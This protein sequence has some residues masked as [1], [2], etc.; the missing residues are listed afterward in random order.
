MKDTF[1]FHKEWMD[2][3]SGL[4]GE[5]RLDIYEAIIMYGT[6]GM[7]PDLK[8]MAMLA[9]NFAKAALD[10]DNERYESICRRNQENG[11]KGGR[12]Q[13]VNPEEPKKPSGLFGN[14]KNPEEPK[15]PNNDIISTKADI[16]SSIKKDS[17]K[18]EPKESG[19]TP[20]SAEPTRCMPD[21]DFVS[22][23]EYYNTTMAGCA[24]PAIKSLSDARR[25]MLNARAKECGKDALAEVVRKA[26]AS[27]F[28]NGGGD[29][30]F[31]ASFDWIFR[32]SNFLKILEGNYDNNDGQQQQP[33]RTVYQQQQFDNIQAAER[34]VL[35]T[36]RKTVEGGRGLHPA[37]PNNR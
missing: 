22:F 35:E 27:S 12:P 33:R 4:P 14:P 9:F 23:L 2:A 36:I 19:G 18:A 10:R 5:V 37:L 25:A 30:A 11:K 15:K 7:I 3:I 29:R 16:I 13:K 32:P 28:L 1:V 8:P 31:I 34:H 6:S 24:I 26:A 17:A 21:I 20:M